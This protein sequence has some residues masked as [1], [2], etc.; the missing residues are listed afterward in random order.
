[1]DFEETVAAISSRFVGTADTDAAINDSLAYMGKLSKASRAYLFLF[2]EGG[3]VM[4][5]THEWC[6]EGVSPQMDNLKNL[7]CDMFPWWMAKL[8]KG[9]AIHVK[10]VSRLPAEATAEKEILESQDIKSLLVRPVHI[11]GE[12]NGF[13]GFD[14]V[15]GAGDWRDTDLANLRISSEIIGN[16]TERKRAEDALCLEKEKAERYPNIAP[17]IILALDTNG[18]I[19]LLNEAGAAILEC[20]QS[21]VTGKNWFD[22]FLPEKVL[23]ST[24]VIFQTLMSGDLTSVEFVEEVV[25]TANGNEKTILGHNSMLYDEEDNIIGTLSSGDDITERKQAEK[26][27]ESLLKELE[28]KNK[29][30]ERFTY[31]VSHDLRSPLITIQG[32]SDMIQNDL[33]ENELEKAKDNLKFIENAATKMEKLLSDTLELSRIGRM[34]NPPEDVPFGEIVEDALEQTAEQIKS[35]GVEIVVANG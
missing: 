3:T 7:P 34:V 21:E 17:A 30:M 20:D 19:T 26:E 28:A 27:R 14:N 2:R 8:R 11:G 22:T 29:E 12:L 31:S 9:E 13:I 23:D 1:M 10:D 4:D 5:N 35:S 6:A 18:A 24:K 25:L 15:V 33:E 32:F 16:A